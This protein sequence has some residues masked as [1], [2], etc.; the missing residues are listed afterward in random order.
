MSGTFSEDS[1]HVTPPGWRTDFL[2]QMGFA[3]PDTGGT[4]DAARPRWRRSSTPPTC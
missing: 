1:V 2:T 3:V 4:V